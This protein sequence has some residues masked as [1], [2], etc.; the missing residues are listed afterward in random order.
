MTNLSTY[1]SHLALNIACTLDFD[2]VWLCSS[3]AV[4]RYWG[5]HEGKIG[6][7]S[8]VEVLMKEW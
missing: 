3:A 7:P 2:L 8:G 5:A 4:E 6:S 1:L